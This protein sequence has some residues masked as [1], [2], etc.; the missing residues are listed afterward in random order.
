MQSILS[1]LYKVDQMVDRFKY[2]LQMPELFLDEEDNVESTLRELRRTDLWKADYELPSLENHKTNAETKFDRRNMEQYCQF[3]LEDCHI[4]ESDRYVD[5]D[6]GCALGIPKFDEDDYIEASTDNLYSLE[7][8]PYQFYDPHEMDGMMIPT[9]SHHR[10]EDGLR[11]VL[12]LLRTDVKIDGASRQIKEMNSVQPLLEVDRSIR[13]M[14]EEAMKRRC[15][16]EL[17]DLYR[18]DVEMNRVKCRTMATGSGQSD[19]GM[20]MGHQMKRS[21][22]T[23]REK[24]QQQL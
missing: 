20:I 1:E 2:G 24:T 23:E 4:E 19:C 8:D 16:R 22:F 5:N 6:M 17:L 21:I 7:P 3:D 13:R 10:E 12:D 18:V 9:C 15:E 14:K 11:Q